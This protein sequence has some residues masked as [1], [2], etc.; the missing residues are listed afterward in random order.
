MDFTCGKTKN[1]IDIKD[2]AIGD[3]SALLAIYPQARNVELL[4]Q[5]LPDP[6]M[7]PYVNQYYEKISCTTV[8]SN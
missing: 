6:A 3:I 4:K 5:V 7:V 1:Y 2:A 8:T